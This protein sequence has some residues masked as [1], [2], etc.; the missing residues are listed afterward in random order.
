MKSADEIHHGAIDEQELEARLDRLPEL[1]SVSWCPPAGLALQ[2][3][4]ELPP[5]AVLDR[6]VKLAVRR[7]LHLSICGRE[8]EP[9]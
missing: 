7:N 9:E 6:I 8:H 2:P 3:A 1:E 5:S 4:L